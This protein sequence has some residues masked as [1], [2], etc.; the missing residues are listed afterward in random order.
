MLHYTHAGTG[1]L[2][3]LA[4]QQQFQRVI[5]RRLVLW[6]GKGEG[7]RGTLHFTHLKRKTTRRKHKKTERKK[8]RERST[9]VHVSA[10]GG[11]AASKINC[12]N[13]SC[14]QKDKQACWSWNRKPELAWALEI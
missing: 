2:S 10:E 11:L 12:A 3:P 6:S 9:R 13:N 5:N 1:S 4:K 14:P 7:G 8:K